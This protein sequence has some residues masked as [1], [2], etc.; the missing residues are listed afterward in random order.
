MGRGLHS[1]VAAEEVVA[2]DLCSWEAEVVSEVHRD[3]VGSPVLDRGEME[4]VRGKTIPVIA[5]VVE[6]EVHYVSAL[7]A[8]AGMLT[9]LAEVSKSLTVGAKATLSDLS[10]AVTW[11]GCGNWSRTSGY[12]QNDCIFFA[13]ED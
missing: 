10:I 3:Q 1:R 6:E 4:Q 8:V 7:V 13:Y 2:R 9:K 11:K 5:V 12:F